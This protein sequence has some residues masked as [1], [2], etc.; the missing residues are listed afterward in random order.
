MLPLLVLFPVT[1]LSMDGGQYRMLY[2]LGAVFIGIAFACYGLC[3]A[4][5]RSGSSA[6]QLLRA[7]ILYLPVLL[8]WMLLLKRV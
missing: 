1:L 8:I 7:S 6:R 4:I 5:R 3:F 2:Q